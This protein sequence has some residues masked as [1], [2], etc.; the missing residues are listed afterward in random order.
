MS[1]RNDD[2]EM[3]EI[4][5]E[6]YKQIAGEDMAAGFVAWSLGERYRRHWFPESTERN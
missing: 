5:F 3:M 2:D 6:Q 4:A 1:I